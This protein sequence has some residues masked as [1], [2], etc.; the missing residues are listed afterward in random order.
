[1]YCP[2]C[3][4]AAS[5]DQRYCRSCG[6]DLAPISA[7]LVEQRPSTRTPDHW[8]QRESRRLGLGLIG[9]A[10]ALALVAFYWLVATQVIATGNVLAGSLVLLFMTAIVLGGVLI[11]YR[12]WLERKRPA[13]SDGAATGL[14]VGVNK[15]Q[16]SAGN[17]GEV[18]PSVTEDTTELLDSVKAEDRGASTGNRFAIK[19]K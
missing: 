13:G 5:T 7:L 15:A 12:A 16:L 2:N 8:L 17:L 18:I 3:A 1:M 14:T 6:F 4:A 19:D 10:V 11:V 9:G